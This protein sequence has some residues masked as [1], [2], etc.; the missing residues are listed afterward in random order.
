MDCE[1]GIEHLT[2]YFFG[3]IPPTA[4]QPLEQHLLAC[5]SC[6]ATFIELKR[7]IDVGR[8]SNLQPSPQKRREIQ[9]DARRRLFAKS[10]SSLLR[11]LTPG[12]LVVGFAA[13]VVIL[14]GTFLRPHKT[15]EAPS[16]ERSSHAVTSIDGII[17][18]GGTIPD[19]INTL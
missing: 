3:C 12:R 6:L 18:S 13:A 16:S 4:R 9:R 15:V 7:D 8:L 1:I 2:E 14:L 19:H 10:R 17:D 11:S 5:R